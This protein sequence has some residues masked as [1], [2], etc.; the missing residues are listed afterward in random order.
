M[1]D[2]NPVGPLMH[3]K[4]LERQATQTFHLDR[5]VETETAYDACAAML[6]FLRKIFHFQ[7]QPANG[8][9]APS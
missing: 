5:E 1:Y 9:Q 7:G 6:L 3:L 2:V 4:E 8:R